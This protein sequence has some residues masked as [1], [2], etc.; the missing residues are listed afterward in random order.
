M[1]SVPVVVSSIQ[2]NSLNLSSVEPAGK[3]IVELV[4]QLSVWWAHWDRSKLRSMPRVLTVE[5]D[6]LHFTPLMKNFIQAAAIKQNY[7]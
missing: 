6:T 1:L 4:E 2:V 3:P 5:R 7:A